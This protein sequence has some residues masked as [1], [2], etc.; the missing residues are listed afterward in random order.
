MRTPQDK[1]QN[2]RDALVWQLEEGIDECIGETSMDRFQQALPPAAAEARL[3][4]RFPVTQPRRSGFPPRDEPAI[5]ASGADSE[6]H[7]RS[8]ECCGSCVSMR[9]HC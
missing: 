8:A 6:T 3:G 5:R 1:L 4:E 7:P 2:A 9:Q